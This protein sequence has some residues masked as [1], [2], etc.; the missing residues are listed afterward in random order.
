[1]FVL[2]NIS[3]IFGQNNTNNIIFR[4]YTIPQKIIQVKDTLMLDY[5]KPEDVLKSFY[6]AN[7]ESWIKSLYLKKPSSIVQD[8]V[9]FE[10]VKKR[11]ITL[12]YAQV[13]SWIYMKKQ[14]KEC[15]FLKYSMTIKEFPFPLIT[16]LSLEKFKNR[17]YIQDQMNQ[18]IVTT[19]LSN[20]DPLVLNNILS[21][22]GLT[23]IEK[24]LISK[25][26]GEKGKFS[27]SKLKAL[28]LAFLEKEDKMSLDQ[29]RDKR[30]LGDGSFGKT[31]S[32]N[33]KYEE[34]K[35]ETENPF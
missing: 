9:H 8:S 16:V 35:Y 2:I 17:W 7:S 23:S 4:I 12:N 1:M 14:G 15:L 20:F 25:T 13:D 30:L 5:S 34:F 31:P 26:K 22:K 28:Y 29:L 33:S 11:D 21:G 19:V 6:S 27:F 18:D 3:N 24:T 10:A 32:I